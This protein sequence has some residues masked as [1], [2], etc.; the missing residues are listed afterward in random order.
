MMKNGFL[1]KKVNSGFSLVELIV[2]IAIFM[3]VG[4]AII[5]F[6]GTSLNSYK[7]NSNEVNIQYESQMAAAQIRDR[8]L[9]ANQGVSYD[10]ANNKL[11]LYSFDNE[12]KVKTASSV[13]LGADGKLYYDEGVY[14]DAFNYT[15]NSS[16]ELFSG[17]IKNFVVS[18]FDASGAAID[19]TTVID[20]DKKPKKITIAYDYQVGTDSDKF[21]RTYNETNE[22]ALRNNIVVGE[23][24]DKVYDKTPE[25]PSATEPDLKAV[26]VELTGSDHVWVNEYGGGFNTTTLGNN[27]GSASPSFGWEFGIPAPT[28]SKTTIFDAARGIVFV[29]L[30]ERTN[31]EMVGTAELTKPA[32]VEGDEP[33]VIARSGSAMIYPKYI[34][35]ASA[36]CPD[37]TTFDYY[38]DTQLTY[39]MK[40]AVKNGEGNEAETLLA[41]IKTEL[42]DADGKS[43]VGKPAGSQK[44]APTIALSGIT[45][46]EKYKT[47][48][49]YMYVFNQTLSNP[50][51]ESKFIYS[52]HFKD[53][54]HGFEA[55]NNVAFAI[56]KP[57]EYTGFQIVSTSN[58]KVYAGQH[59]GI[60]AYITLHYSTAKDADGLTDELL[61]VTDKVDFSKT[62]V[63]IIGT[64]TNAGAYGLLAINK[65]LE[66]GTGTISGTY[67]DDTGK[68]WT[69][70][71][72]FKVTPVEARLV[73]ADSKNSQIPD[74]P[75]QYMTADSGNT[76]LYL[77]DENVSSGPEK[78]MI[79]SSPSV[80]GVDGNISA[81][82]LSASVHNNGKELRLNAGQLFT[83][84]EENPFPFGVA[85]LTYTYSG[86]YTNQLSVKP[87]EFVFT[88]TTFD[89]G[90]GDELLIMI[91][92]PNIMT[93][94]GD[95][96][97]VD[98]FVPG[99]DTQKGGNY[100]EISG[101]NFYILDNAKGWSF[102]ARWNIFNLNSIKLH[103]GA[104][105]T[106]GTAF[107]WDEDGGYWK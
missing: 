61:D 104:T 21:K 75:Y 89:T 4:V 53:E 1:K 36:S 78:L 19:T 33:E 34:I 102:D 107:R 64:F 69:A 60:K 85:K 11:V 106:A 47:G 24:V 95:R 76:S 43:L 65:K 23:G 51:K 22:I 10:V 100:A 38:N 98:V 37:L 67:V 45:L 44:D 25:G 42:I 50:P 40:V 71:K 92:N 103:R 29:G 66:T 70:K 68:E 101:K 96:I 56:N 83:P 31:F 59:I 9:S 63:G 58:T 73:Q 93:S 18:I 17:V 39:E 32:A 2:S 27:L 46:K 72:T 99:L 87:Y 90:V 105:D 94:K 20:P 48:E 3:I 79:S 7:K 88:D 35:S 81:G 91:G 12:T 62:S 6:M 16:A 15:S 86:N 8:V 54:A 28:D 41:S 30:D 97:A 55:A 84:S 5:S 52:F 77:L 57:F 80:A 14:D 49:T 74:Q 13:Y 82:I 26:V